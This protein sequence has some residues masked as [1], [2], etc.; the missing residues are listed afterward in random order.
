M[1]KNVHIINAVAL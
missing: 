1:R